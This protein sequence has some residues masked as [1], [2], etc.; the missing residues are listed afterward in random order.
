MVLQVIHF[1][2]DRNVVYLH[3]SPL[4]TLF[5]LATSAESA[6]PALRS[7]DEAAKAAVAAAWCGAQAVAEAWI[8]FGSPCGL[9]LVVQSHSD[10][11]I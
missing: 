3:I 6:P 7:L 9:D 4:E 2:L 8:E 5:G 11:S 10:C 1:L